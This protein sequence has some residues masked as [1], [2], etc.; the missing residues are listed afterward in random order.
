MARFVFSPSFNAS[1]AASLMATVAVLGAPAMAQDKTAAKETPS[2]MRS[3]KLTEEKVAPAP[4]K[5]SKTER[6]AAM[7]LEP[8]AR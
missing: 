4:V 3:V 5:A 2:A 6:A 8:L 7:R 1:L